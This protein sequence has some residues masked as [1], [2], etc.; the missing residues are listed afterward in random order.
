MEEHYPFTGERR[1]PVVL[2]VDDSE[3]IR[4]VFR[5]YLEYEGF[6]VSC[7]GD[8]VHGLSAAR[9]QRPDVIVMDAR[10]PGISGLDALGQMRSDP[11][12]C[13]I[14]TLIVTG[15]SR[16]DA[17]QKALAA[18]AAGFL[19]KPCP[20]DELMRAIQGLVRVA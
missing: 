5:T 16:A 10:L 3:D 9:E 15:D 2:I 13:N 18:G 14:P 8:A 11:E 1:M 6:T 12:L 17:P 20:L 7:A 19:L 4:D